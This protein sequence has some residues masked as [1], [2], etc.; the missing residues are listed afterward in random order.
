[1]S[2]SFSFLLLFSTD[3]GMDVLLGK[4]RT[5]HTKEAQR[6]ISCPK[7]NKQA[8][9]PRENGAAASLGRSGLK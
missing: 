6:V 3:F 8:G 1:V 7:F 2:L 9:W 5:L 4:R